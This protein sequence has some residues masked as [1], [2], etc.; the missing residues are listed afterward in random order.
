MTGN[1]EQGRAKEPHVYDDVD[2]DDDTSDLEDDESSSA[3]QMS[4]LSIT[5]ASNAEATAPPAATA[6]PA[7]DSPFA[8]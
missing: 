2:V 6:E 7:I 3:V 1:K 5:S 4:G 8:S